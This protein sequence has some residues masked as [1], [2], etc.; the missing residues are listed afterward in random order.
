MGLHRSR[1][2][3]IL[4]AMKDSGLLLAALLFACLQP[5]AVRGGEG[6]DTAVPLSLA[7]SMDLALLQHLGLRVRRFD[8]GIA[9]QGVEEARTAFLPEFSASG[10]ANESRSAASA[11]ELEGSAQ[12]TSEARR[13][14]AE[15]RQRF[16]TGTRVQAGLGTRRSATDSTFA[17]LNPAHDATADASITQPLLRGA[18]PLV[19]RADILRGEIAIRRTEQTLR[20]ATMDLLVEVEQTYWRARLAR[21]RLQIQEASLA[22]AQA[23]LEETQELRRRGLQTDIDVLQAEV[24]VAQRRETLIVN[25]QEIQ[26]ADDLLRFLV[27]ERHRLDAVWELDDIPAVNGAPPDP[28]E[29]L[30]TSFR[31]QP[32][33]LL[34]REILAERELSG[35]IASRQHRPSLD[36]AARG[37]YSGRDD[38]QGDAWDGVRR[39]DGYGWQ[40]DLSFSMPWG[41]RDSAARLAQARLQLEQAQW[42]FVR[43]EEEMAVQ[44]RTAARAVNAGRAR[45][46]AT[47]LVREAAERQLELERSRFEAGL[48][49]V[50]QV[51]DVQ[52]DVEQARLRE[53]EARR[54]TLAAM[55]RLARLEGS[56]MERHGL[57]WNVIE[58]EAR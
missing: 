40:V 41:L 10:S 35:E 42:D 12:P 33:Y 25:R 2:C 22:A 52:N 16:S 31:Q 44:I 8:L 13:F 53:L 28:V 9:R 17:T 58:E 46:D 49:T 37:S 43:I 45:V 21:W 15:V 30:R 55:V 47:R 39:R 51:L 27:G 11:S 24:G 5:V 6:A 20:A 3:V 48:L 4:P 56:V 57:R 32:E 23:L 29:A 14:G 50:R 34:Q 18:G 1:A 26:D 38:N 36:L 54:D 7:E 19:N